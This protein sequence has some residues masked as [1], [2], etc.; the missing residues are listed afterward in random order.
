MAILMIID[1][2]NIATNIMIEYLGLENINKTI[3]LLGFK[4]TMLIC[5]KLD[6]N[7]FKEI[8]RTTAK[9]YGELYIK[10]LNKEILNSE[11]CEEILE[12]LKKQLHNDLLIRKLPLKDLN[13]IGENDANIK[14]IASKSGGLGDKKYGIDNCRNDGG[15]IGT[16]F[17][18]YIVSIFINN[19][20]D[21]YWNRDNEAILVGGEIN[22]ILYENYIKNE[23]RFDL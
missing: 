11:I 19:F 17:G 2:D 21:C 20:N 1:S 5:P 18:F 8:G 16:K 13:D 9:E 3:K 15:I 6:F 12:I 4:D 7:F 14:Y 22:R 10:L 23:G